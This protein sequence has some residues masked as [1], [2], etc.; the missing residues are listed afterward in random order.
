MTDYE[1]RMKMI[2]EDFLDNYEELKLLDA[3]EL[4]DKLWTPEYAVEFGRA[5]MQ[6]MIEF[7]GDELFEVKK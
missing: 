3:D 4:Q 5:V 6:D 2:M 7:S 1:Y